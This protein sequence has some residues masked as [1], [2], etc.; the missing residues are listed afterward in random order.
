MLWLSVDLS[1]QKLRLALNFVYTDCLRGSVDRRIA[2]HCLESWK[3]GLFLTNGEGEKWGGLSCVG[4]LG[5]SLEQFCLEFLGAGAEIR[6]ISRQ[7]QQIWKKKFTTKLSDSSALF[8]ETMQTMTVFSWRPSCRPS[9]RKSSILK[10]CGLC[11]SRP[12]CPGRN[13]R[14]DSRVR[15]G[16]PG[17]A[18]I[19]RW[20]VWRGRRG[21][22][23][24]GK[25]GLF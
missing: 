21:K 8:R 17:R 23:K 6:A 18:P 2:K 4:F 14:S 10:R 12:R 25:R 3:K 1:K 15:P 7:N 19:G 24:L 9:H 5:W 11:S 16:H 20:L 22:L 13:R